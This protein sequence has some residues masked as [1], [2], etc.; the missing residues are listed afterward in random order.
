[1]DKKKALFVDD[2]QNV[3]D[4][5]RRMLRPLRNQYD[6]HFASGGRQALEL[7]AGERFD[8]IISD[9]RM[10]GMDGAEL[11][12]KVQKQ[13]PHTI[14]I[15]LTGQ[16]DENSILRTIGVVHQFLAKPCD[17]ERLKTI[18]AQAGA[19]QEILS[20]GGLK[21]LISQIGTLPSLPT[22]YARLQKAVAS[23]EVDINE[24]GRIIERDIAMTAKVLQLVNS[25]FFGIYTKVDSPIKAVKL[26]GLDTIKVLVLGLE[27]FSQIKISKDIFPIELLWSRSL[28]VG[29]IAKA[30]AARVSDDKDLISNAFIAGILHDIGK[31]ILISHLPARY[32]QVIDLARDKN[33][34][35]PEAE[36]AIFGAWQGAVGAYLIGLWGFVEPIIEALGFH[37]VLDRYPATAFT[38]ALAVHVARI[39]YYRNRPEE[40][41]GRSQELYL[42]ALDSLGLLD[43][44]GGW[45]EMAAE[46]M[47]N[48]EGD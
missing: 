10:P 33:I 4:G 43:R 18:L 29:K 13:Y 34:T 24:V 40:I 26:L 39:L 32:R 35:L 17:P 46:I 14:R 9:M 27:I 36:L 2:E 22:T 28:T 1:M 37:A 25:A 41:I 31:L 7:M 48:D 16:A 47:K 20:D 21:D 3:L 44:V 12:E 45:V 6:I 11:L 15:M 8:V 23:P 5:L 30:I 38:P 42:P 19:L